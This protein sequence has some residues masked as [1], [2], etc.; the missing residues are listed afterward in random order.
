MPTQPGHTASQ[1]KWRR[2]KTSERAE[3]KLENATVR[4][5]ETKE[6]ETGLRVRY[7]YVHIHS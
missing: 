3:G 6:P 7:V 2:K 5:C 1:R 4:K